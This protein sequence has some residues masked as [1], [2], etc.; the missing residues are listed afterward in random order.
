[1]GLF[2]AIVLGVVQGLTEFLSAPLTPVVS[3]S[4]ST[5]AG[6]I[7]TGLDAPTSTRFSVFLSIPAITAA[8]IGNAH[9]MEHLY[10]Q[11]SVPI[12]VGTVT[13]GMAGAL[14]VEFMMRG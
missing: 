2:K 9:G 7:F 12:V 10:D 6:G 1:M 13:A 8:I 11:N 4:G 5:I 14:A 3:R